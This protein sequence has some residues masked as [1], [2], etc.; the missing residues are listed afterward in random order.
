MR[1]P[2][3]K[4]AVTDAEGLLGARVSLSQ[5]TP[6]LLKVLAI[7]DLVILR[8]PTD[9]LHNDLFESLGTRQ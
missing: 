5:R 2:G 4:V 9:G 3:H 8:T 7:S 1:D 6:L